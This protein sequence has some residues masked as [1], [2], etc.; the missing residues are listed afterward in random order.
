MP[1]EVKHGAAPGSYLHARFGGA[2]GRA[3]RSALER[4]LQGRER[5]ELQRREQGFRREMTD[6]GH[7]QSME[8]IGLAGAQRRGLLAD[9]HRQESRL[10]LA[11]AGMRQQQIED[12]QGFQQDMYEYRFTAEQKA[13]DAKY[14]SMLHQLEKS[15]DYSPEEK[16]EYRRKIMNAMAGIDIIPARKDP[17]PWAPGQGPGEMWYNEEYGGWVTRDTKGN[18]KPMESPGID[19]KQAW[20]IAIANA[21]SDKTGLTDWDKAKENY[22]HIMG[23]SSVEAPGGGQGQIEASGTEKPEMM[24]P[25]VEQERQRLMASIEAKGGRSKSVEQD[26]R[27]YGTAVKPYDAVE[28]LTRIEDVEAHIQFKE[29]ELK[30]L[31]SKIGIR[32]PADNVATTVMGGIQTASDKSSLI[33]DANSVKKELAALRR[34]LEMLRNQRKTEMAQLDSINIA[35]GMGIGQ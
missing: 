11:N 23:A 16:Y 17:S 21:L 18:Q 15:E 35:I 28:N 3:Y 2:E 33:S 13:D 27:Q 26:L 20:E 30:D 7:M 31:N 8:K 1:I 25:G 34:R 22:G 24:L 19:P 4:Y 32:R 6:V 9:E 10:F 29:E 14:R 5:M 12:E